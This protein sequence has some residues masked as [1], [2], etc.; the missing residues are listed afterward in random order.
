MCA[1]TKQEWRK[2]WCCHK[3]PEKAVTD[4][5]TKALPSALPY[6]IVLVVEKAAGVITKQIP[7]CSEETALLLYNHLCLSWSARQIPC[8]WSVSL[9]AS[10]ASWLCGLVLVGSQGAPLLQPLPL[11]GAALQ[12]GFVPKP[13]VARGGSVA[14][15]FYKSTDATSV[16]AFDH[17]NHQ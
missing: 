8:E 15:D 7:S 4:D 12:L 1:G 10:A 3:H 9:R 11:P 6:L 14:L 13:F 16:G 17:K 5:V 2:K